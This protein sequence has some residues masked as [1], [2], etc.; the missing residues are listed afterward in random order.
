MDPE[1]LRRSLRAH[2]RLTWNAH[3]L[4]AYLRSRASQSPENPVFDL[5]RFWSCDATCLEAG[6]RCAVVVY[7]LFESAGHM[8]QCWESLERSLAVDADVYHFSPGDDCMGGYAVALLFSHLA[9]LIGP[10][11]Y[12]K[13]EQAVQHYLGWCSKLDSNYPL[14]KD[15]ERVTVELLPRTQKMEWY[16]ARERAFSDPEDKRFCAGSG[17]HCRT[18]CDGEAM[19]LLG[20]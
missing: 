16:K 19:D 5:G 17:F 12:G 8:S 7:F 4:Y 14:W 18:P 11:T 15:A 6:S 2:H 3:G 13:V 1:T 10:M 20:L 9:P